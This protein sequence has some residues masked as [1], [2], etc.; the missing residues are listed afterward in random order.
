MIFHSY[1]RKKNEKIFIIAVATN[2][3][4]F[5][6]EEDNKRWFEGFRYA[7]SYLQVE[8]HALALLWLPKVSFS[9]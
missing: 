2:I 1:N 8:N 5:N 7:A 3:E 4:E 6:L 9:G